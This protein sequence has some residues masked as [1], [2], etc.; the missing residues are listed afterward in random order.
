MYIDDNSSPTMELSR[1]VR[2][3]VF[4]SDKVFWEEWYW[5][6]R[7]SSFWRRDWSVEVLSALG[8]GG[9]GRGLFP[10]VGGCSFSFSGGACNT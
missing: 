4:S 5:V 7:D 2:R 6:V 1:G 8:L 10:E 3:E 9:E